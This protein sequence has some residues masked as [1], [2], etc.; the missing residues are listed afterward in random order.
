MSHIR[1]L[2]ATR[3]V[4]ASQLLSLAK[5]CHFSWKQRLRLSSRRGQLL[6]SDVC[7]PCFTPWTMLMKA[8]EMEGTDSAALQAWCRRIY[9]SPFAWSKTMWE[10]QCRCTSW[11]TTPCAQRTAINWAEARL[12]GLLFAEAVRSTSSRVSLLYFFGISSSYKKRIVA[13]YLYHS[14]F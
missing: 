10:E 6:W 8:R 7:L 5:F 12:A 2:C 3:T 4:V 11:S 1:G 13:D 9:L 14:F